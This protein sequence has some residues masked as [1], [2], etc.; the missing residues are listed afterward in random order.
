MPLVDHIVGHVKNIRKIIFK[1]NINTKLSILM[2]MLR[3]IV[4]KIFTKNT[5]AM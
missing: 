2:K 1:A 3:L 4:L 5:M